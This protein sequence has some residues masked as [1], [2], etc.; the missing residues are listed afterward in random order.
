MPKGSTGP[1]ATARP[2]LLFAS[3]INIAS[4]GARR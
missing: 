4:S 3:R 2:K 1:T